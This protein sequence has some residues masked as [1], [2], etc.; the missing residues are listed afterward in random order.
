MMNAAEKSDRRVSVHA[1]R[2]YAVRFYLEQLI[3]RIVLILMCALFLLPFY[4]MA[5]TSLKGSEELRHIP[6]TLWPH[7]YH[8]E[9]YAEA[10]KYIP[11]FRYFLNSSVLAIL[12]VVGAVLTNST[13]AYG[14]SRIEWRGRE[15]LSYLVIST[16]FI[17]FPVTLV[18]L[19][20]IFAKFKLVN[21]YVPL[22][23]PH[24]VG[25]ATYIFMM[26]QFLLG[27]PREISS[28]GIIDGADEM[29]VF[30]KLILP[31]MRPVIAVVAIFTAIAS[32]NDFMTPLIYLQAEELYPL[33][34]GLQFF[35]AEHRI[36]YSMLMAASTLVVLPVI[37]IFL[38]FQRFF[39]E[40]I[41]V[42]AV[43]G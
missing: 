1:R 18:A 5:V 35:R 14:L 6:P 23:L 16:M 42:G 27:I 36:E 17:P 15:P 43:K 19:F 33:S 4:W 7:A 41:T 10:V 39:V 34:I 9:N 25:S 32:W 11:F 31:L 38:A 21:T 26:R 13:V 24:F 30:I 12:S 22:V 3:P 37:A 29:Q 8:L 40:G 20:D 2:R 28:A